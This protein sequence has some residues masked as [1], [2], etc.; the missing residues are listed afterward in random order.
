MNSICKVDALLSAYLDGELPARQ[1]AEVERHLA[2]CEAC[3]RSLQALQH[4]DTH[5]RGMAAP[6]PS[7]DFDRRFW[8]KVAAVEKETQRSPWSGFWLKGWRPILA[9]GLAGLVAAV[10]IYHHG[11]QA[12][13]PEELFIAEHMEF[14]KNYELL[15]NLEMLEQWD[16]MESMKE[17]S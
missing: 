1:S 10:I 6:E 3:R 9:G 11:R 4:T 5:L 7:A 2:D 15:G 16:A 13:G 14:L 17:Q 12:L 8:Q